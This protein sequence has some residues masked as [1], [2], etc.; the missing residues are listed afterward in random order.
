MVQ[1]R[2]M[3][4]KA[5]SRIGFFRRFSNWFQLRPAQKAWPTFSEEEL[6]KGARQAYLFI[7]ENVTKNVC[8][9][10]PG[11]RRLTYSQLTEANLREH[12]QLFS[13][14]A[15]PLIMQGMEDSTKHG[16]RWTSELRS[17]KDLQLLRFG[18]ETE[19]PAGILALA[20]IEF[21]VDELRECHV[22]GERL[23]HADG[24]F[25]QRHV[26]QTPIFTLGPDGLQPVDPPQWVVAA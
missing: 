23:W 8:F 24:L 12:A 6:L 7:H 11:A 20:E 26:F 3:P 25:V 21:L 14:K 5:F 22:N 13:A 19:Q 2:G 17:L 18:F 15:V 10:K 1:D 9:R 16:I 4:Q